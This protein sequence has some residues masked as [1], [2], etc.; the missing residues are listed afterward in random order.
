[1]TIR[2]HQSKHCYWQIIFHAGPFW[3]IHTKAPFSLIL[4]SL[5]APHTRLHN[6]FFWHLTPMSTQ[7]STLGPSLPLDLHHDLTSPIQDT[8]NETQLTNTDGKPRRTRSKWTPEETQDLI[9]GCGIHGVG[10]WKK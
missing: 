7:Q 6:Y 1:L 4:I 2:L 5:Q 9:T 3:Y 10:N 8:P